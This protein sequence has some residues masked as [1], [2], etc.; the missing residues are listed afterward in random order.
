[1]RVF[2]S[3][4]EPS[5]DEHAASLIAALRKKSPNIVCEGFGGPEMK[6]AGCNIHTQLTDYAVMGIVKVLPLIWTFL[7]IAWSAKKHFRESPPDLVVLVD[8]PGFNWWIAHYAKKAGIRVVYYLPPQLWAWAP[9]RIKRMQRNVDY[10]LSGLSFEKEWYEERGVKTEFVSHP[11]FDEVAEKKLDQKFVASNQNSQ[12]RIIGILPGSRTMEVHRNW[13][14]IASVI[15]ELHQK[16]PNTKF[17]VANYKEAHRNFCMQNNQE[18]LKHTDIQYELGKTSEI[19]EVA[20]CC[21]MV[22]GS[23]SLELLARET[24]AVVLYQGGFVLYA[25]AKLLVHCKYMTLPNLMA[26]REILPEFPF[27][28]N[29]KKNRNAIYATL[30]NWISDS[31]AFQV[32]KDEMLSLKTEV[33]QQGATKRVA[34]FLIHLLDNSTADSKESSQIAA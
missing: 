22:S 8:F 2:F 12:Q 7:K 32:V 11:F 4:G 29:V 19:I 9:W 1:M 24:P 16:H 34:N 23:V 31:N 10:V 20:E 26:K 14:V 30:D 13:S 5:G 25:L 6:Q 18:E 28:F 21:L 3:V 15:S 33:A 27:Y 17:I